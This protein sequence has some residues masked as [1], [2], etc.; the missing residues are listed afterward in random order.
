MLIQNKYDLYY[1]T[2]I[3]N[4]LYTTYVSQRSFYKPLFHLTT[5]RHY[6]N[7][8][9][10]LKVIKIFISKHRKP[11]LTAERSLVHRWL[12]VKSPYVNKKVPVSNQML[13]STQYKVH[14]SL[15]SPSEQIHTVCSFFLRRL[16]REFILSQN[17]ESS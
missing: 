4:Q 16:Q 9:T 3:I 12:V 2:E 1:V 11:V 5:S 17:T 7:F 14:E 15:L 6:Q 10:A 8:M 13:T